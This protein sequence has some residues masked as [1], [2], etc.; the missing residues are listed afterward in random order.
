MV[1]S[2]WVQ[3]QQMVWISLLPFHPHLSEVLLEVF[4]MASANRVP[5]FQNPGD[6]FVANFFHGGCVWWILERCVCRLQPAK[7]WLDTVMSSEEKREYPKE[8]ILLRMF[9]PAQ[10]R[11][12]SALICLWYRIILRPCVNKTCRTI[13]FYSEYVNGIDLFHQNNN[14]MHMLCSTYC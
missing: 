10:T 4:F 2:H 1:R 14:I 6:S 9:P 11:W 13:C 5:G 12:P 7:L 8:Q 3:P